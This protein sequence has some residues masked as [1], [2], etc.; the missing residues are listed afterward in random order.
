METLTVI[1]FSLDAVSLM[2]QAHIAPESE[3]GE[4]M[5]SLID[6]ATQVGKPKAVYTVSFVDGRDGDTLE[7]SGF[8]FT[9]RT[10]SKNLESVER[11][12]PFVAT[13]GHEMDEAFPTKGD[14]LKEFWWELIK[15]QLLGT[16]NRY[17]SDHLHSKFRLG[18][19]AIMRPGSGDAAVWPI[20]Q[21]QGLFGLLG[22]VEKAI[23]VMLTDS[24]LMIPNK[25]SSGILF[26]TEKDFR[27]C[28]VCHRERCPSRHAPFNPLLWEEV[29]NG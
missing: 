10:L 15:T 27:S 1:P 8:S 5:R 12:F 16:A 7:I 28:E 14:M 29:Q 21:Q 24:S 22:D 23:G 19:T 18:K 4:E 2:K 3:D 6:R 11:I 13:C 9:S 26:P 20:E 17:L 25:T